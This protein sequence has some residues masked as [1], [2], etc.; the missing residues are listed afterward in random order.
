MEQTNER[1]RYHYIDVL[2]VFS[3]C[4]VMVL[5][6]FGDY[7]HKESSIGS[8]LWWGLGF[9]NELCRAGVPIF[10]M[11]SGFLLLKNDIPDI[12]EFY[13]RRLS[14][15]CIPFLCY[16]AFYFIARS[17]SEWKFAPKVFI[18]EFLNSGSA[19]H[20]WFI[21]SLMFIYLM[22]PFVKMIIDRCSYKMLIGF[23]IFSIFQTTIKPFINTLS[24]GYVY[25][26]LNLDGIS[27]YLG[28]AILGYILGTYDLS[29]RGKK[30]LYASAIVSFIAFPLVSMY[31]AEEGTLSLFNGGYSLN[32]Y[33]EAAALFTLFK[34]KANIKTKFFSAMSLLVMD[35]YFIHVYIAEKLKLLSWEVIPVV[36]ITVLVVVTIVTS[37]LW[38][39]LKEKTVKYI[40]EVRKNG[41][42]NNGNTPVDSLSD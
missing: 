7:F 27:G 37:F 19:Y 29:A 14:K 4:L 32:H 41:K 20:L 21:Y 6:C 38:A 35:A 31:W 12:K 42:K 36:M 15:I 11:I 13:K 18:D 24:N 39:F 34:D 23:F 26:Y 28:Y 17:I 5:H 16:N 10:F 2:R 3:I 25:I 33:I 22:I 30:I 9:V 1:A 40:K 8:T